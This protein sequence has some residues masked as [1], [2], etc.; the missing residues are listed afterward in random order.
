MRRSQTIKAGLPLQSK[1]TPLETHNLNRFLFAVRWCAGTIFVLLA[2][3]VPAARADYAVLQSGQR[4]HIT[5]YE[6]VGNTIR[7]TV[8]G[9]TMEI[10]EDSVLT[11]DAED[12]F[13]P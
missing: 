7:L 11:F 5:S 8:P 9:G 4:I 2:V 3:L 13:L 6:R 1:P 12:T 10:P